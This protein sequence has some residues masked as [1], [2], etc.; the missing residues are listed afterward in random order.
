M[1]ERPATTDERPAVG[2]ERP[3]SDDDRLAIRGHRALTPT[4]AAAGTFATIAAVISIA[5]VVGHGGL[6]LPVAAN[7]SAAPIGSSLV[8]FAS[9]TPSAPPAA[10]PSPA[11][12]PIATPTAAV[13][14]SVPST[15]PSPEPSSS[16]TAS[17]PPSGPP[18][19]LAALAACPGHPGCHLY[20]VRRGDTLSRVSDRFEVP[21]WVTQALNPDAADASFIVVGQ[22]L[23]LGRDP[24]VLLD[25]CPGGAACHLYVIQRGDTVSRIGHRYHLKTQAI[26][27]L[28]PRLVP[29]AMVPGQVIR[30]PL[31]R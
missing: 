23:Y 24:M 3:A 22:R 16:P 21:L 13:P 20:V 30:L 9:P 2:A 14:S 10:S 26:L 31:Y 25:P 17:P 8:A 19:P 5:F 11:V 12:G 6:Q 28:N 1:D 27:D 29:T 4:V 15:P 7:G 18:D